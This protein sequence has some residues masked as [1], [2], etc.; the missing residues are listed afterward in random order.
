MTAVTTPTASTPAPAAPSSGLGGATRAG[1]RTTDLPTIVRLRDFM[2]T[3]RLGA[4]L[5][6]TSRCV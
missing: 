4:C 3:D 6:Y 2:P 1:V 5:L